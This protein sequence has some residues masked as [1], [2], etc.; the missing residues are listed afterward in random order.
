MEAT[1]F[2]GPKSSIIPAIPGI[3]LSLASCS[4]DLWLNIDRLKIKNY[5]ML[6]GG[7]SV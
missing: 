5:M 7:T 3:A 4:A 1:E 6:A 2:F